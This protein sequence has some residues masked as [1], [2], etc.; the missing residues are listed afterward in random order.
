MLKCLKEKSKGKTALL[1]DGA[2]RTGKSFICEEFEKNEYRSYIIVDFGNIS[3]E[4]I[5][6]FENE[7]NDLDLFFILL[8]M[9]IIQIMKFI[10]PYYLIN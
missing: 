6:L 5:D 7:T 1:I 4:I 3:K 10:K 8:W 2:R 9:G